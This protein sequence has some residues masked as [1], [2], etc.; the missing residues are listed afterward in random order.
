MESSLKRN[1]F[2]F[3]FF[4]V[5]G[6]VSNNI[7]PNRCNCGESVAFNTPSVA[8]HIQDA[9]FDNVITDATI[10]NFITTKQIGCV[11][12]STKFWGRKTSATLAHIS[13][14]HLAADIL[15]EIDKGM[16]GKCNSYVNMKRTLSLHHNSAQENKNG[17]S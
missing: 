1:A 7:K 3:Q 16:I 14:R 17:Y 15:D 11:G 10:P 5:A 6:F 2:F 8:R 4:T 13:R 9:G 12:K